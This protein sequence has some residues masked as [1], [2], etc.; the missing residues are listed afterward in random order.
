MDTGTLLDKEEEDL[1]LGLILRHGG[2]AWSHLPTLALV[3]RYAS[4][5]LPCT[6]GRILC[7]S[8]YGAC[9]RILLQRDNSNSIEL[10]FLPGTMFVTRFAVPH[11][12]TVEE[13][14]R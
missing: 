10:C 8:S 6:A 11:R 5:F 14:G 4:F 7:C 13:S 12:Q 2:F 1:L 9:R 3:S